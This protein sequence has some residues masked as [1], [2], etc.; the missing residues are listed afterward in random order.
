MGPVGDFKINK[1][2]EY[3]P[4]LLLKRE[5]ERGKKRKKRKKNAAFSNKAVFKNEHI[6]T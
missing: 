4:L 2:F 3:L 6:E 5:R 1:G